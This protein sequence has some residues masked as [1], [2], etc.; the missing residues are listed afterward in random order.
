MEKKKRKKTK[1]RSHDFF[2]E[3][4]YVYISVKNLY[5]TQHSLH[6]LSYNQLCQNNLT[7]N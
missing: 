6:V 3:K 5:S 2:G 1:D 4:G 7:C